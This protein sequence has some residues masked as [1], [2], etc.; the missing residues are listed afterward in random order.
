MLELARA[1]SKLRGQKVVDLASP[2]THRRR[3]KTILDSLPSHPYGQTTGAAHRSQLP[4]R[5]HGSA[6]SFSG[7]GTRGVKSES[8]PS[9]EPRALSRAVPAAGQPARLREG[10]KAGSSKK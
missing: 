9:E 10:G 4:W 7:R 1:E 3:A 5:P 8:P 2:T 6:G